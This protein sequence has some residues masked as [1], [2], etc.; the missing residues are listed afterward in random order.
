[1]TLRASEKC[2][3]H[4]GRG[5][6]DRFDY[7]D[8]A[9][10]IHPD[11][12]ER[13]QAAVARTLA[14]GEDY[15]IEYRN[16]WP[17]RSI[18]WVDVRGRVERGTAGKV[19]LVVGVS[20]DITERKTS[21][22]ERERLLGEL[23]T[24]RV[25][26]SELTATLEERVNDR[27]AE[28]MTEVAA[29]EKA[30]T[31]LVQSQKME[32]IGQL[33][34]GVAHDFNNLLMAVM[35][36]LDLLR[37][38]L[39]DDARAQRLINNA[40]QGARRGAALTQR[41]LAFA[42]QQEL[43]TSSADLANLLYG[44]R[45]LLDRS[46]GPQIELK[47]DIREG[48]PPAQIDPNQIELAVL[49][50]AINSRDAMPTGGQILITLRQDDAGGKTGDLLLSVADSGT[51]MNEETLAKAIE[52]FFSTKPVGKGTGLGLSM[53]HGLAHQS[54]GRLVLRS[55]KGEG[56]SAELWLP[57]VD[58]TGMEK[59]KTSAIVEFSGKTMPLRV[60]AV[61]DDN[62]VLV[63]TIA[64]LE[65]LG[66]TVFSASS[67]AEALAIFKEEDIQLVVTDQLMPR[68]TGVQL[69]ALL[70]A[71]V[72][73]LPVILATGYAEFDREG[74]RDLPQLAKP[75]DQADLATVIAATV[76]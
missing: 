41:M 1:M 30:Q 8:L 52:P 20:S 73:D 71:E 66:H 34:G 18:H 62:L 57:A 35:G 2:R 25:A 47:L 39:P 24:E 21:E 9:S 43:K 46:L 53:V 31:R 63:N 22:L 11:D 40:L 4:F 27:T 64:M 17:D 15:A 12:A 74:G 48:L 44:M 42:R 67:G 29:R 68:M 36:S 10:S 16:I 38:R 37:K 69:A 55:K 45:D 54:G 7:A 51:G 28:L 3:A 76:R 23:A 5:S 49:N 65:D 6:D 32:S 70:H 26:L 61:D 33:T 58:R 75:F 59:T 14:S 50:L 56:T 19:E 13:M 60:L 72:P